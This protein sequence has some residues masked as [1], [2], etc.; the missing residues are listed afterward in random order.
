MMT[1]STPG[2]AI[3]QSVELHDRR[4]GI[5]RFIGE[6]RF[7]PGTW[8]GV[9]LDSPTGKNDGTVQGERY[10]DC[11]SD[12]GMFVRPAAVVDVV[13]RP[14]RPEATP[15]ASRVGMAKISSRPSSLVVAQRRSLAVA[16][17][18]RQSTSTQAAPS[19][20]RLFRVREEDGAVEGEGGMNDGYR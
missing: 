6:T 15:R 13:V 2:L 9:E 5:V 11:P 17:V 18:K 1:Q 14:E 12:H 3:G 8:V 10:F 16:P 19:T 7:A 20:S 4:N